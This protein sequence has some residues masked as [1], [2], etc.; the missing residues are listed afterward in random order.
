MSS[1]SGIPTFRDANGLWQSFDPADFANALGIVKQGIVNPRRLAQFL[2]AFLGPIA[3][4][5]AQCRT[6]C[7]HRNAN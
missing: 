1:E 5:F 7:N 4:A 6:F 3:T 2:H